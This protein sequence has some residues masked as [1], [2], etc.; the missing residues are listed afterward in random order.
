[1]DIALPEPKLQADFAQTLQ[2][3]RSL[4][5]QDALSAT[6]DLIDIR[7]LDREL[8][9]LVP[10]H[11]LKAL[12][13]HGLRGELLF[14][15]PCLL[16][17]NPRLLGYYR[18]LLGY[19]QKEFYNT[20]N[21]LS[22]YK[23]ME[24]KGLLSKMHADNLPTLCESLIASAVYLLEYTNEIISSNLLHELSLLTLGGQLRGRYNVKLGN[25]A[26]EKVFNVI[27]Q[28]VKHVATDISP[29]RIKLLNA[30]G[31]KIIIAFSSD[32]DL[33]IKEEIAEGKFYN[34][35]AIEIKGGTDY[36]NIHNRLG[37]A[38]K[39]HRKARDARYVECWTVINVDRLDPEL[40]HR[41]SPTTDRFYQLSHL[42]QP[43]HPE[44]QDFHQRILSL[45]GIRANQEQTRQ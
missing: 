6:V 37:E 27:K 10:E 15:V 21:G 1:M 23:S 3:L 29:R 40:A 42:M 19:S 41:E 33:V 11:S 43:E 13:K 35:I 4:Y 30:A 8:G 44:Y 32:P 26:N 12:A 5:L 7:Q 25:T 9:E 16:R 31:N 28:M 39:S 17:T 45:I 36:S 14:A 22:S 20:Y 24:Q 38:E 18:L 34:K 2:N